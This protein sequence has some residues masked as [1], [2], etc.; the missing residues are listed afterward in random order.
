MV[1][2][3]RGAF[4]SGMYFALVVIP[5][6]FAALGTPPAGRSFWTEFSV[7]LG[8]VGLS[9]MGLQFVLL[10]RITPIAAPFGEDAVVQFHRQI[11]YAGTLFILA[12]P[13]VLMVLVSSDFVKLLNPVTAPWRARFGLLSIVCLVLVMVTSMW[14]RRLQIRYEAWQ[15]SHA[16][17]ATAAV[18]AALWHVELV[19][20]YV[21]TPWK[22]TLWIVMTAAFVAVIVW[23]RLVK[24][25]MRLRRPWEIAQVTKQ[26]G[27]TWTLAFRPVGHPGFRFTPGQFGWLSVNRSPFSFTQHPFSF[28]SSAEQDG[29][30]EMSIRELGDFTRTVGSITPGARAYLDGPYGVFS[31]D[32]YEGPGFV[33]LGGG[34]GI[35]PLTGMLRTFAD[36]EEVRPCLLFH[37]S[38]T[39]EDATFREELE[40]LDERLPGYELVQVIGDPPETWTGERGRIDDALLLRHLPTRYRRFQYFICGPGP[41]QD[42]MEEV[43]ARIGVPGDRVHTER[44]NFV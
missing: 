37:A 2:A 35:A 13:T 25:V 40:S 21:S 14:R 20:F 18:V 5:L 29:R 28:S 30:V 1:Q 11:A 23:V 26:R 4:W 15:I 36:R 43:L 9:M 34:V 42:G 3:V 27:G 31:P 8:F 41:M 32:R 33:F 6:L 19:H 39:L 24:P 10:A 22:R 7:A 44:F 17:L 16:V 12:H 38:R